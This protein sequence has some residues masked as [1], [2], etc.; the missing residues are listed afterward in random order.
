MFDLTIEGICY[1]MITKYVFGAQSNVI[2]MFVLLIILYWLLDFELQN[3][4]IDCVVVCP[5][6]H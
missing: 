3:C 6:V 2:V 4:E 5:C 1:V